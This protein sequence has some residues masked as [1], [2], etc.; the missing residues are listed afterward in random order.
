MKK[1]YYLLAFAGLISTGCQKQPIISSAGISANE[2]KT[3]NLTLASS[4]YSTLGSTIYASKTKNF[5]SDADAKMYIPTILNNEYPQL[6]NGSKANITFSEQPVLVDSVYKDQQYTLVTTP[7]NDYKLLPGNTFSDFSIAQALAW[8]PYKFPTP[9]ATQ[10]EILTFA[11]YNGQ[12]TATATFAF[13]YLNGTWRQAYL[14]TPAQY[15]AVGRPAYSEFTSADDANIPSFLNAILKAD[16]SVMATAKAG[17]VQYVSFT[18]YNSAKVTTQRVLAMGFD[19]T[20]WSPLAT[21]TLAFLKSGGTWIADPTV[22]YTLT[23]ADTQL[24][25]NPNGTNNTTIGTVAERANLYQYGD[26][27]GW[28][29]ADLQKAIIL[30]LTTDF[31]SPK[32]NINYVVIYLNYTGGADVPTTLTFQYNGTAWIGQ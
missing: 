13:L 2:V 21:T 20:N 5:N 15:T 32:V 22:Y 26:F 6:S 24:I 25:G 16:P 11:Y 12:T 29:K 14:L 10:E 3:L 1:I 23:K 19:G 4:D 31:P 18:Y 27:S 28:A 30:V 17:S 9:A 7:V 8:L